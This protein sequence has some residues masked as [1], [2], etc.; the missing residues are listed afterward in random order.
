MSV[1]AATT[2]STAIA[3]TYQSNRGVGVR[4]RM[5]R[6]ARTPITAATRAAIQGPGLSSAPINP[7][8]TQRGDGHDEAIVQPADI[9]GQHE[10]PVRGHDPEPLHHLAGLVEPTCE[11]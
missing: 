7:A 4:V 10:G 8:M 5:S 3:G 9:V 6:I 1:T 2:A 11:H